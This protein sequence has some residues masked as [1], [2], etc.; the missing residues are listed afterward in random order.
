VTTTPPVTDTLTIHLQQ[1]SMQWRDTT[2]QARRD[3]RTIL[4]RAAHITGFTEVYNDLDVLERE[5]FRAG[6]RLYWKTKTGKAETV[7]AVR[8]DIPLL[9]FDG[10]LVNPADPGKPPAGGHSARYATWVKVDF[11]GNVVFDV[12]FHSVTGRNVSRSAKRR[13]MSEVIAGLVTT[14]ARGDAIGFWKADTNADD[15]EDNTGDVVYEPLESAGLISCWDE[16]KAW[17]PTH[18]GGDGSTIDVI[19]SY[20]KDPRVRLQKVKPWPYGESDHAQVS[21]WYDIAPQRIVVPP[22]PEPV[23]HPCPACGDTHLGVIGG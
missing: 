14:H 3:Y 13:E 9:D 17:P 19:G 11:F 8:E 18:K 1:A 23:E 20:R 6:Y 10:V 22:A 2:R 4:G 7:Q 5:A 16:V 12:E 21:A 15:R